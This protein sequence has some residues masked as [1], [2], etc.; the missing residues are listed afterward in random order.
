MSKAAIA[1]IGGLRRSAARAA[2]SGAGGSPGVG[3]RSAGAQSANGSQAG[4]TAAADADAAKLST[5]VATLL[6]ESAR[7]ISSID[8]GQGGFGSA[9]G[10]SAAASGTAAAP[11]AAEQD[12]AGTPDGAVRPAA[13]AEEEEEG[14]EAETGFATPRGMLAVR[15]PG[16]HEQMQQGAGEHKR[17]GP[18]PAADQ[19]Q[20]PANGEALHAASLSAAGAPA[21]GAVPAE[22]PAPSHAGSLA[23]RGTQGTGLSQVRQRSQCCSASTALLVACSCGYACQSHCWPDCLLGLVLHLLYPLPWASATSPS[24]S[25]LPKSSIAAAASPAQPAAAVAHLHAPQLSG[26]AEQP[27]QQF[28]QQRLWQHPAPP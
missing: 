22:R 12:T 5:P 19:H 28:I 24:L 16:Q 11:A 13:V 25:P 17:Q 7:I 15:W 23:S 10:S 21:A 4:D 18:D 20:V 14:A 6:A 3:V 1:G 2:E 27:L 9:I 8:C 26:P